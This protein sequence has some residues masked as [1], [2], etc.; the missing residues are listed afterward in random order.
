MLEHAFWAKRIVSKAARSSMR[1]ALNAAT[2]LGDAGSRLKNDRGI[3]MASQS[4]FM[5]RAMNSSRR[6]CPVGVAPP[7]GIRID[8]FGYS[9]CISRQNWAT[10]WLGTAMSGLAQIPSRRISIAAVAM[11]AV[12]PAPTVWASKTSPSCRMRHT[13]D[14]WWPRSLNESISPRGWPSHSGGYWGAT[15]QL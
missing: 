2:V 7:S 14:A 1:R 10:R 12:L 13:A 4:P 9:V 11:T 3:T 5:A 15:K 8:A 6:R